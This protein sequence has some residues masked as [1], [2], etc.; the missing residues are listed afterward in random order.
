MAQRTSLMGLTLLA[1]CSAGAPE[2]TPENGFGDCLRSGRSTAATCLDAQPGY[3]SCLANSEA[4]ALCI[5]A[6]AGF[7]DCIA[8]QFSFDRCIDASAGFGACIEHDG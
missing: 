7:G 6:N 3:A 4:P 1:A 8:A 5:D 2:E